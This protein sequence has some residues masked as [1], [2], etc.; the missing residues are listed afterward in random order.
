MHHCIENGQQLAHGCDQRDLRW[1]ARGT[2][3]PIEVTVTSQVL[4]GKLKP[5][6]ESKEHKAFAAVRVK[7][8]DLV[9]E[10]NQH[11]VT[12]TGVIESTFW[13]DV[14]SWVIPAVLSAAIWFLIFRRLGQAQGGGH[15]GR[16]IQGEDLHGER[17][18]RHVYRCRQRG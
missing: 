18:Q 8:P 6:G 10:L 11:G 9:R 15:A 12:F 13:R 2:E 1:L 14:L 3:A 16:P 5:E 4:T 17:C 7:D